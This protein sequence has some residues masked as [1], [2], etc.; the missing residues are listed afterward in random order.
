MRLWKTPR[1][2][3]GLFVL[4][5]ST[6][7]CGDPALHQAN[8]QAAVALEEG[9]P[10]DARDILTSF[11]S[12]VQKSPIVLV[13]LGRAYLELGEEDRGL[14]ELHHASVLIRKN[15]PL[16][17]LLARTFLAYGEV[18]EADR[19]IERCGP[20][21]Q[22]T[23]AY[24]LILGHLRLDVGADRGEVLVEFQKAG[25][26]SRDVKILLFGREADFAEFNVGIN[27]FRD[28]DEA[29]AALAKTDFAGYD[30]SK[31]ADC[32]E[33]IEYG[34]PTSASGKAAF[35]AVFSAIENAKAGKL[36]VIVTAPISKEALK[37]AGYEFTGHTSIFK[38]AFQS[39][40]R[41]DFSS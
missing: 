13:N 20:T 5:L 26:D 10:S 7:G 9:R 11:G 12:R 27:W 8:E 37:L 17:L 33:K 40:W 22:Q 31:L 16:L 4:F 28:F 14:Q 19:I 30:I 23:A 1:R 41:S 2:S 21:L 25:S 29:T 39:V 24:H 18:D 36:A 15:D 6:G 38:K 3:I 34:R 35:H 32:E